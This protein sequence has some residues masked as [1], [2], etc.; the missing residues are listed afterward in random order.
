MCTCP[1][2]LPLGAYRLQHCGSTKA[3]SVQVPSC[4]VA[5]WPSRR[6]FL[7]WPFTPFC[8][9]TH[10]HLAKSAGPS[11]GFHQANEEL[12]KNGTGT[13]DRETPAE[14]KGPPE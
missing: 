7:P 13:A 2:P 5:L 3:D 4:M 14:S 10:R 12:L 11:H 8:S 1:A 9:S 6:E